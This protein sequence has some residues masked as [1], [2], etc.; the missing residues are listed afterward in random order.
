MNT[1]PDL[2]FLETERLRFE[3]PCENQ[4]EI[5]FPLFSN[6][7]VTRHIGNGKTYDKEGIR[8]TVKKSR[9]HWKKNN[10][11]FCNV[12]LKG[13]DTFIGVGGLVHL[14][15]QEG[16]PEFEL[17]YHLL[18]EFWEKGYATEIAKALLAW[19]F[20]HM[21]VDHFLGVTNK[22]HMASQKVLKKA[23]F[24]Y[25]RDELYPKTGILC[26]FFRI[27]RPSCHYP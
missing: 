8:E 26:H 12:F 23:G 15:Y 3:R 14:A 5:L 25:D 19:G 17:G 4:E 1:S 21:G 6:P 27:D 10:I 9:Q 13:T 22:E 20:E 16:H 24:H 11:G 7:D 18:P 2:F